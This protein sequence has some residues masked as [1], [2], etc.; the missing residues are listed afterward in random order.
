MS[1]T[2]EDNTCDICKSYFKHEERQ[3]TLR[4]IYDEFKE[5]IDHNGDFKEI[6]DE[7]NKKI[8]SVIGK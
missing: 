6:I 3:N 2:S 1:D 8:N 4:K 5:V 7:E